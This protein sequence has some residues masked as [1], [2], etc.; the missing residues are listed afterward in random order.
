MPLYLTLPRGP[1]ADLA[2]P[3]LARSD[4][5]VID[6]VLRAIRAL[7]EPGDANGAENSPPTGGWRVI[8]RDAEALEVAPR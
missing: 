3:V 6:A 2:T 7:G 1:R 4:P 5:A 8:E